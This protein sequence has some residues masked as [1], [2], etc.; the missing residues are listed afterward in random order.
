MPGK[1]GAGVRALGGLKGDG[2]HKYL[3]RADEISGEAET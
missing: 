2:F 1:E 3:Q